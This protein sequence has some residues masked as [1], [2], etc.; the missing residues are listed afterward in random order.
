[1][2]TQ[3]QFAELASQLRGTLAVVREMARA[4]PP[5][6]PPASAGVLSAISRNGE[7]RMSRLAELLDIDMSVTSRHVAH[8]AE[9]GW[10][11]RAPDPLDRRSRLLRLTALGDL[12]L[13]NAQNHVAG[14]LAERLSD[15]PDEDV[16]R[17]TDLLD[18]LRTGF[19]EPRP[20]PRTHA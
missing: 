3:Q 19:C 17:F 11:E 2:A 14:V 18:R 15:W 7:I 8:L 20:L 9:R 1:M 13:S 6:C 10:I 12:A 5:D 4:M 16:E